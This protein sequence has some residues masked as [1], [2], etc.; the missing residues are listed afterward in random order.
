MS[1][2][3]LDIAKWKDEYP[4]LRN[5]WDI[6]NEYGS[7]VENNVK[8]HQIYSLCDII[9]KTSG[10]NMDEYTDFCTKLLR[11]LGH[12]S[13]NLERF[14]RKYDSCDILY[15]WI[16]NSKKRKVI[17]DTIIHKGFE[18]Y[19]KIGDVMKYN[20]SCSY[21]TYDS[22]Y[23]EPINITLLNIFVS[24][25]VTIRNT[26]NDETGVNYNPCRKFVCKSVKIYNDMY[27]KYC[28]NAVEGYEKHTGT[29]SKLTEF[30][31]TYKFYFLNNIV[32]NDQIPSLDDDQKIYSNKCQI[33]LQ[34]QASDT[35]V[36]SQELSTSLSITLP[37][38]R[39]TAA[40]ASIN[41][42]EG[43]NQSSPMSSTVST[44]L[45]TVAGT[46]SILALL[47]KFTPGRRWIHSVFGRES[48]RIDN[49][50]YAEGPNELLFQGFESEDM[51]SYNARYN[52]GY[53]SS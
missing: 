52:I 44:A 31:R 1:D 2:D 42:P 26:L 41:F 30:Y 25:M 27:K 3:I 24:N 12:F 19:V 34:E 35:T 15:N 49:N 38:D 4:F 9:L 29:C 6:Y 28:E 22:L 46:S 40:P 53:G 36:V 51:S 43:E 8:N 11:N 23:K 21:D 39:N 17:P 5:V 37:Q 48:G 47:Y 45:G 16:Y 10:N 20:F 13:E 18:D 14:I 7:T 32:K 33:Y 50:L